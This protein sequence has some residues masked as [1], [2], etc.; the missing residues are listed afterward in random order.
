MKISRFAISLSISILVMLQISVFS[1]T[2]YEMLV[3]SRNT[4]S[5]KRFNAQTGAYIDD[6]ISSGSGG[7]STTQDLKIGPTGDILVSGRGNTKILQYDKTTG[8]FVMDFTSGYT[9]DNPTKISFGPDGNLYVSQWGTGNSSVARFNGT[10]GQFIN[11]F[12][13]D[14]NL[15]LDHT[16]DNSG[17]LYVACYG[18]KDVRKF[19]TLGNFVSIFTEA[20]HLQGPT[21][22]WFDGNGNMLVIDWVLGSVQKFRASDGVFTGTLLSGLQ[23]AEGYAYGADS[24]LYICDWSQNNVKKYNVN[25]SFLG[26]F[27]NG[28]NLMAPNS[29]LIRPSKV[30]S[31][32]EGLNS[33]TK[34][35]S[36][37][38]N[39]PNPFNP[40]TKFYFTIP[41]TQNVKLEIYTVKGNLVAGLINQRLKPGK[42]E[43]VWEAENYPS[44]IYF[45]QLTSE[46]YRETKKMIYLK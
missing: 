33:I 39:Y 17:N 36:L 40:S 1:Q 28:G 26:I 38:Q 32:E 5:V 35:F 18:S 20:G 46:N 29:I 30:I 41:K 21:N 27:T 7:L 44:G 37:G 43:Y 2:Q 31:V 24:N 42:Y 10:N 6:F 23:N 8:N 12:T 14:L 9:L 4:H 15:P 19:D 22:L 45:Y 16:W 25:G 34:E 11:E 13:P 3:S